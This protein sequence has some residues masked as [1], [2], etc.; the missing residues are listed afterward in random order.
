MAEKN[1]GKPIGPNALIDANLKKV[2]NEIANEE[3]P[4][5]FKELL[6][7]LRRQDS[8]NGGSK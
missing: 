1:E 4:S 8:E 6:E 2:Y 7:Q 3:L 5:R